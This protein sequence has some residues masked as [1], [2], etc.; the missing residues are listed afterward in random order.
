MANIP[1]Q[2]EWI[3]DRWA[4]NPSFP[5]NSGIDPMVGAGASGHTLPREDKPDLA[6]DFLR[7]VKTTGAIYT[8]A[9]ARRT[10]DE[11]AR[12]AYEPAAG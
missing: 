6:L 5:R 9:P 12:G 11:I 4:N 8:F 10:L 7:C 3:Q 1:G 2:F